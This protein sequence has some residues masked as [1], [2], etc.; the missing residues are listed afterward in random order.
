[1]RPEIEKVSLFFGADFDRPE[2][3]W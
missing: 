2:P 3:H 1:M